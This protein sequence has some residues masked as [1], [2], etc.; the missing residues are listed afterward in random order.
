MEGLIAHQKRLKELYRK[1]RFLQESFNFQNPTPFLEELV[2][3]AEELR[4]EL[5]LHFRVLREGL[6]PIPATH[7]LIK[8]N[9][10]VKEILERMLGRIIEKGSQNS[11]DAFLELEEFGEIFKAYLKKERGLLRQQIEEVTTPAQRAEIEERVWSLIS[12]FLEG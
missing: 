6:E 8:E 4:E 11:P 3:I 2:S 7:R 9:L 12:P 1:M 5:E 10:L